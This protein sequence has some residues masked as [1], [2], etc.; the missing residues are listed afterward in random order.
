[1]KK[2]DGQKQDYTTLKKYYKRLNKE[3]DFDDYDDD[4]T[5]ELKLKLAKLEYKKVLKRKNC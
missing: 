2:L 5:L 1:M 3:I 4:E